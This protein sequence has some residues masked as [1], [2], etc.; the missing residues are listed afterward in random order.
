[1]Q[2]PM[3]R[4]KASLTDSFLAMPR[5]RFQLY[6]ARNSHGT[7]VACGTLFIQKQIAEVF[8]IATH[9]DHRKHG[10]GTALMHHLI[11]IA[12]RKKCSVVAL[13]SSEMGR[14]LYEKLGFVET[15]LTEIYKRG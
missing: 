13:Q 12:R 8:H 11:D 15:G 5:S 14:P 3:A 6:L 10:Y 1:M 4:Y 9:P 7:A 2:P